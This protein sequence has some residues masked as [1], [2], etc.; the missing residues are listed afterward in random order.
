MDKIEKAKALKRL[1]QKF[2]SRFGTS[3]YL[4][5]GAVRDYFLGTTKEGMDLDLTSAADFFEVQKFLLEAGYQIAVKSEKLR[6]LAAQKGEICFDLATFRTEEYGKS[7]HQ[8]T[9]VTFVTDIFEDALRRDFTINAIYYDL[10][11][12]EFYDPFNGQEDI[13]KRKLQT[14]AYPYHSLAD[15]PAR[16]LRMI[17]LAVKYDFKILEDE[18]EAVRSKGTEWLGHLSA[19]RIR[20]EL[21]KLDLTNLHAKEKTLRLINH[22]N[23]GEAV[24]P[25]VE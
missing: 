4:V 2:L 8:P 18:V 16:I 12:N 13:F 21:A 6:V 9:K 20:K 25:F 1:G 23:L 7:S 14:I 17:V 5:G 11:K 22:L 24:R 10:S 15:D 3:L 19:T